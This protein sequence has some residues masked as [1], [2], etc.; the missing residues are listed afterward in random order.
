MSDLFGCFLRFDTGEMFL[1]VV[2]NCLRTLLRKYL[3]TFMV[4]GKQP[5]E[6]KALPVL[7]ALLQA[8]G[9][10]RGHTY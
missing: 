1:S 3:A 4:S 9:R 2:S 6:V 10:D 8:W 5:L 7:V